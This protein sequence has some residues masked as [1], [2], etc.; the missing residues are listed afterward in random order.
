[1]IDNIR[2]R[3][4]YLEAERA[5]LE[6]ELSRTKAEARGATVEAV[7]ALIAD[8]GDT[9]DEIL[10]LLAPAAP[11]GKAKR[12]RASGSDTRHF[13]AYALADDP[14]RTYSRG[15]LPGWLRERM[16]DAGLDPDDRASR[17]LFREQRMVR[18]P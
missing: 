13:P 12:T 14:G 10:P 4:T 15:K 2:A 16:M 11:K 5:E 17:E 9:P 6:A 18:V 1:M 8:A 3:L 7:R